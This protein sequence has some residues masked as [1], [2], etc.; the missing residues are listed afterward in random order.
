ME[1]SCIGAVRGS[2]GINHDQPVELDE[3]DPVKPTGQQRLTDE[4][5]E[6]P[7]LDAFINISYLV[8]VNYNLPDLWV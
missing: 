2:P 8:V 6:Y 1:R 4:H 5:N 7:V 3:V